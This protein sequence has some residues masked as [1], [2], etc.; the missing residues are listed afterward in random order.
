VIRR[1]LAFI[2]LVAAAILL[3]PFVF[4]APIDGPLSD[5]A[6]EYINQAPVDLGGANI[7]TSVIVT[8]RGL[9]T[10]GEVAVLFAAT[11]A[12][13]LLLRKTGREGVE[14][15]PTQKAS[16]ILETGGGVLFPLIILFGV[17]I[18]IHGHLTPGGGFQ[19][20]VVIATGFLL[21]LLS[22]TVD[23]FNHT[24]MSLVE[25][26]SGLAYVAV[27]LAGLIW[28]A[29]FLDPRFLPVGEFG[30]LFSAGAIPVI[31]SLI[32]LKVGAELTGI[33]DGMSRKRPEK[34]ASV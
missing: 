16:E 17:Y 29:G 19:G 11:A 22:G 15:A 25:S 6:T 8:Y 9:D 20:G 4:S 1:F 23:R 5:L 34:G 33:L 32:G 21:L 2:A 3:L 28:A 30:R 10:L 18:F 12:I 13:G 24:L 14:G 31:Y 7:V 27:G 26:L